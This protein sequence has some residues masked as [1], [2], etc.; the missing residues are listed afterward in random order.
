MLNVIYNQ[1]SFKQRVFYETW[2]CCKLCSKLVLNIH[3]YSTLTLYFLI[4][5]HI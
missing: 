1:I 2:V 3:H 5:K 4:I